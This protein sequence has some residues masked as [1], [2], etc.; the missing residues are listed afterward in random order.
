M[1][2]GTRLVAEQLGL[3][4]P[5][6][7]VDGCHVVQA[8]THKSLLQLP[9]P[10]RARAQLLALLCSTDLTVFAFSRDIIVHDGRGRIYLDYLRTWS[11]QMHKVDDIFEPACWDGFDDLTALV[12]IG[13]HAG[14]E[15]VV[16][17]V[18]A[19][20][21]SE[22]Q[23]AHFPLARGHLVNRWVILVRRAGVNKGTAVRWL[24]DHFG[25][26]MSDVIAVGDWVNDIPM[27]EVAGRS[28]VMGQAPAEVKAA[29]NN[30]L[31]ATVHTGGAI[32]EAAERCGLI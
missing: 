18:Q 3:R 21:D 22:I 13:S 29:A 28:F 1:Y 25:I 16:N 14:T 20:H 19:M 10:G 27:F 15:S 23:L 11:T 32:A 2:S 12:V 17:A 24:A 4:S 31:R 7:C 5:V 8:N 6:A 30:E 26:A 9:I